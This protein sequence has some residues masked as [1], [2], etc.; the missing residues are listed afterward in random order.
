[1]LDLLVCCGAGT[2]HAFCEGLEPTGRHLKF[3]SCQQQ[4]DFVVA[5]EHLL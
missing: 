3:V 1:M 4:L 2:Y 5:C